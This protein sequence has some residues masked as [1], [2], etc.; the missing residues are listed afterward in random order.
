MMMQS[1]AVCQAAYSSPWFQQPV[2]VQQS[3]AVIMMRA[4]RPV[5]LRAGP[6]ATLSLELFG[7]VRK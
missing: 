2:G 1:E 5:R 3:V 6:F 4:Q 7:V